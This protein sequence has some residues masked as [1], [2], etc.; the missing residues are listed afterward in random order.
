MKMKKMLVPLEK[1]VD[2]ENVGALQKSK[3]IWKMLAPYRKVSGFGKCWGL[4]EK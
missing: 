2:L 3:Q 1:Y 4:T